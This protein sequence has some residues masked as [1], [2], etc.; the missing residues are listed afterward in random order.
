MPE[1]KREM[2]IFGH[3]HIVADVP[4]SRATECFN[5]Y[6]LEDGSVLRVKI[7]ATAVLRIEGQFTNEGKPV[8]MVMTSP[9][10]YVITST[11]RPEAKTP[12]A[13]RTQ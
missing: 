11:I 3:K 9:N 12:L 1:E 6:E 8:Y 13:E 5:D 4:I 2:E 7:V 10:T